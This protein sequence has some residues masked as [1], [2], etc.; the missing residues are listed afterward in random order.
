[1]SKQTK[2]RISSLK[3]HADNNERVSS[4]NK[5]SNSN[6]SPCHLIDVELVKTMLTK[7]HWK[8]NYNGDT[9]TL[10]SALRYVDEAEERVR[11]ADIQCN[12]IDQMMKKPKHLNMKST[13]ESILE[14]ARD[15]EHDANQKYVK[16]RNML[17][18]Q[19][20]SIAAAACNEL[21]KVKL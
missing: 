16:S 8:Q 6:Q 7:S 4:Y 13:L 20:E 19:I 14:R 11:N 5:I 15:A 10:D 18:K 3:R 17:I 2:K 21:N 9:S 1:M 12:E